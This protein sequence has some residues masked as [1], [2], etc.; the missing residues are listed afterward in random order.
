MYNYYT[1]VVWQVNIALFAIIAL[2]YIV[3][4]FTIFFKDLLWQ[5]RRRAILDLKNNIYEIVLANKEASSA[6]CLPSISDITP[7]QY[8]DI[9]TNRNIDTTFFNETEQRFFRNCFIKPDNIAAL[10]NII[11]KSGNKWKKIEAMLCL[12]YTQTATSVALLKKLIYSKD[13]DIGY[14]SMISLGQIK[15]PESAGVLL[16]LLKK[17]PASGYK[18]ISILEDFPKEIADDIA[19]LID[20]HDPKVRLFALTLLSKFVSSAHIKKLEKLAHDQ[21]AQVRAAACDCLR[22]TRNIE[23]RPALV[24]RLKDDNW[25][26]R[27]RAVLALSKV[28][29][30]AAIPQVI[31]LINDASWSVVET[32]KTVMTEHIKASLPYIEKFLA[33]EDEVPKKYSVLALQNSGYLAELL[34]EVVSGKAKDAEVRLLQG[35]VRSRAHAGLDAVLSELQPEARTKALEILMKME[36]V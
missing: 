33:G 6:V 16:D 23:A 31:G 21:S 27:S 14:F 22:Q 7:Q 9:E 24:A 35:V 18:I 1:D 3:I 15:T 30:D 13:K 4:L 20:Y 29:E 17:D 28:M 12:G 2:T 10:E 36:K 11:T 34:N 26:V 32:V 25:L 19:G 5:R 8:I